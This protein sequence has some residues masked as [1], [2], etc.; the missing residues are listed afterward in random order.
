MAK[1]QLAVKNKYTYHIK[2][3]NNLKYSHTNCFKCRL[4][5]FFVSSNQ[6]AK[7]TFT[8]DIF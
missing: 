4:C 8:K 1:L 3:K 5:D 6:N 2:N 7:L